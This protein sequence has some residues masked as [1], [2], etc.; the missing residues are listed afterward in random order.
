MIKAHDSLFTKYCF[1]A[2]PDNIIKSG[3][4]KCH[5]ES[6]KLQYEKILEKEKV[7]KGK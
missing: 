1:S 4:C 2:C 6:I 3:N 7:K 5:N